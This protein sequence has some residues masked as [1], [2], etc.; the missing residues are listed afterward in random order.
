[1]EKQ[2]KKPR[3]TPKKSP[4]QRLLD[5]AWLQ[6]L[7]TGKINI[8][9]VE[10]T[11]YVTKKKVIAPDGTIT[12]EKQISFRFKNGM[13]ALAYHILKGNDKFIQKILD[14][15][16]ASKTDVTSDGEKV[17]GGFIMIPER[18]KE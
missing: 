6:D 14:K 18:D 2:L 11:Q 1:M 5:E 9:E 10:P 13:H 15:L 4:Y 16:I 3:K 7:M 8:K 17:E 12:F